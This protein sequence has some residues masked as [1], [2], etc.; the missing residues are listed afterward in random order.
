MKCFVLTAI[1]FLS[2]FFITPDKAISQNSIPDTLAES[3]LNNAINLYHQ[4][5]TPESNLYD[6]SEYAYNAYYPFII[7]EGDPFFM[8]TYFET[9][10][11]FYNNMLFEKVPLLY[12]IV[13]DEILIRD[14]TKINILRLN[15]ERVKWFRIYNKTFIR[16]MSDSVSGNSLKTGFYGILYKGKI[17]LYKH[18]SKFFKET[19]SSAQGLNRYVVENDEYFITRG[20][21]YFRIKNKKSLFKE[22]SDK[23]KEIVQF[24]NK[25]K[26]RWKKN[27]ENTLTKVVAYYDGITTGNKKDNN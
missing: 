2:A 24:I 14:P 21:G 19:S 7:N 4:Y 8:S 13:K 18:V 17:S 20:N 25:N 16:L 27:K 3:P 15:A 10:S 26:L 22:L 11:V 23:K 12:D 1:V 6:G 9:G 5:L